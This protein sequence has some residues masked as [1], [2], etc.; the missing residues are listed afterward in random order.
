V[1]ETAD[2]E[3]SLENSWCDH[4][5]ISKMFYDCKTSLFGQRAEKPLTTD[6]NRDMTNTTVHKS[7]GKNGSFMFST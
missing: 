2:P 6:P 3:L 1:I 4:L 7:N 5:T